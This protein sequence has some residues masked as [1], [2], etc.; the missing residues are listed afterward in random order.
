MAE[1]IYLTEEEEM[2][3]FARIKKAR[4]ATRKKKNFLFYGIGNDSD[5]PGYDKE[6]E[7]GIKAIDELPNYY[8]GLLS[9]IVAKFANSTEDFEELTQ[10]ANQLFYYA[11]ENFVP[12]K[13]RFSTYLTTVVNGKLT[14]YVE[15]DGLFTEKGNARFLR[16]QIED[17][18]KTLKEKGIEN[19]TDSEIGKECGMSAEKVRQMLTLQTQYMK[20]NNYISLDQTIERDTQDDTAMTY[21]ESVASD[22]DLEA[23][24]LDKLT[25]ELL[26]KAIRENLS[27]EEE[28]ILRD[29]FGLNEEQMV[30]SRADLAK[31]YGITTTE[32]RMKERSAL[33]KLSKIEELK[34]MID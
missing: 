11:I 17:A 34:G 26:D 18:I 3:Y 8:K 9:S 10:E 29:R 12:G 24:I 2:E 20:K 31:K 30:I 16:R 5:I 15:S 7:E 28:A 33:I 1:K 6:I 19:P 14:T 13:A 22:E 21:M 23:T 27:G 32:V 4:I 25:S